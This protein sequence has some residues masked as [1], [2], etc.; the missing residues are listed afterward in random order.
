MQHM[1]R[2]GNH[3]FFQLTEVSQAAVY[4]RSR[5]FLRTHP[6][7]DIGILCFHP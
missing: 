3:M 1:A 7:P 4:L 6:A 2:I 5:L